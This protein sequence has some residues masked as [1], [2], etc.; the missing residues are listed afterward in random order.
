MKLTRGLSLPSS[1]AHRMVRATTSLSLQGE[2]LC[3]VRSTSGVTRAA[4]FPPARPSF[5]G[6]RQRSTRGFF[7]PRGVLHMQR[8]CRAGTLT[9]HRDPC[10]LS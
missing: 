9:S 8:Y 1:Q 7:S 4:P 5:T 2:K 3:S 6:P 10:D